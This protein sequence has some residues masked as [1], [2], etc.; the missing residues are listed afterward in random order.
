MWYT[1]SVMKTAPKSAP[2][3]TNL[4]KCDESKNQELNSICGWKFLRRGA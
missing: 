1:A 2:G 4:I 3:K